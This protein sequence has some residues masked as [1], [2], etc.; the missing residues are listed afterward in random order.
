MER[1]REIKV[2]RDKCKRDGKGDEK[3]DMER[4]RDRKLRDE[5]ME[6]QRQEII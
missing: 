5:D 1:R 2:Q 3:T 4:L 6:R